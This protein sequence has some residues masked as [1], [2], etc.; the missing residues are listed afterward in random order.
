MPTV[1][2][3]PKIDTAYIIS[4]TKPSIGDAYRGG[5]YVGNYIAADK[6]EYQLIVS[7]RLN[8]ESSDKL[9]YHPTKPAFTSGTLSS[10]NDGFNSTY[11]ALDDFS[12]FDYCKK[13]QRDITLSGGASATYT[14]WYLP[15]RNELEVMYY[16]LKPNSTANKIVKTSKTALASGMNVNSV[17]SRNVS[18]TAT[19]PAVTKLTGFKLNS[20]DAFANSVYMSSTGNSSGFVGIN[21][22]DG[23]NTYHAW[24]EKVNVRAI[25]HELVVGLSFKGNVVNLPVV[26]KILDKNEPF[27]NIEYNWYRSGEKTPLYTSNTSDQYTPTEAGDYLVTA[28]YTDK[29]NNAQ[30]TS[31]I[32]TVLD[33]PTP[34]PIGSKWKGGYY[35]GEIKFKNGA[36]FYLI[37][38]PRAQGIL[39]NMPMLTAAEK[40]AVLKAPPSLTD[41]EFDGY[42]TS[43]NATLIKQHA[44]LTK[45]DKLNTTGGI[46]GFK[47]WYVPS[48]AELDIIYRH[49]KPTTDANFGM[50][51]NSYSTDPADK[52][53]FKASDNNPAQTKI[54][55][56]QGDG[57][58]SFVPAK[59][60]AAVIRTFCSSTYG[61]KGTVAAQMFDTGRGLAVDLTA[62]EW[63]YTRLIRRE[64]KV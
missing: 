46:N 24:N 37:V 47:D 2:G 43:R 25:R 38:S 63:Q 9:A 57:S 61:A 53:A 8:G 3:I 58:E 54:E 52:L 44:L 20:W 18:Y 31:A 28:S 39:E 30:G 13:L 55:V 4:N 22:E 32:V 27:T 34:G 64:K 40:A 29:D 48:K 7:T 10:T 41:I 11:F 56:F 62:S 19:V 36:I 45:C 1:A 17:P 5:I 21:F 16:N 12:G 49:F 15:S 51:A 26:A 6:T 50:T 42:T 60:Q 33:S 59:N 14:D 23:E 35:A